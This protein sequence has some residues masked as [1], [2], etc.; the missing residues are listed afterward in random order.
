MEDL[1]LFNYRNLF[2]LNR[3]ASFILTLMYLC[4]F[5]FSRTSLLYILKPLCS[6]KDA[7]A[8]LNNLIKDGYLY[9]YNSFYALSSKTLSCLDIYN[10]SHDHKRRKISIESLSVYELKS[11]IVANE[12]VKSV[13]PVIQNNRHWPKN[14]AER[15]DLIRCMV[16]QIQSKSVPFV[17]GYNTAI[18]TKIQDK[19]KYLREYELNALYLTK[20]YAQL[21]ASAIKSKTDPREADNYERIYQEIKQVR[22]GLERITPLCQMLTYKEGLKVLSLAMLE[23]NGLYIKSVGNT[24]ITIGLINSAANSITS[25]QLRKKLDYAT[26]FANTLGL[27]PSITIYTA[28]RYRSII[29]KRA[30]KLKAPFPLPAIMVETVPDKLPTRTEFLKKLLG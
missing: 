11:Y 6:D 22:N 14:K 30:S 15:S 7:A 5:P 9:E 29:D 2:P 10:K 8:T 27:E 28:E 21:N 1:E 16:K 4:P 3:T 23:R 19:V 13:I 24:S 18:Y 26:T 25:T 12:L 17:K 20:L